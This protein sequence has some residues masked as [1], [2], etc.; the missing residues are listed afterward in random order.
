M[1]LGFIGLGGM[2]S[3]M[4]RNLVQA[5]HDL[6]VYNRTPS[7]ADEFRGP[8][9]RVATTPAEAASGVDFVFT[10]L[11]DDAATEAVTFG[12]RGILNS[13]AAGAAH[14]CSS[15]ISVRLS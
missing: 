14:I 2:G 4:A 13:L 7:R 3:A 15:T 6:V 1:K 10:M 12:E 9:V 8:G 5:G 11:A